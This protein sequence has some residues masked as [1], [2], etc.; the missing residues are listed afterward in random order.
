MFLVFNSCMNILKY[1]IL[2]LLFTILFC[3]CSNDASKLSEFNKCLYT[4]EY[5]SGFDIKTAERRKSVL[6]E[7]KDPWQGANKVNMQL[8]V[9]RNGESVPKDF[10]GQILIGDA[11]RIVAMSSTHIGMLDAIGATNSI[12]GVSGLKYIFS[13]DI[14]THRSKIKDIGYEGN[15]NYE[16]LLSLN[17]DIV[18]IYGV[19]GA[20]SME[21]KLQEL[22]IP[23]IYIGDYLE[24]SPLG[25]AE[26]MVAIA[27]I[28]GKRENGEKVFAEIPIKYNAL[29]KKV[30]EHA[31]NIPKV[32]L[33]IP[34]G[35]TWFMPSVNNYMARLISDAGGNYLYKKNISNSS[36]P[37]DLEE[38]Y[39]LVS[40]TD[41]WLN[42]GTLNTMNE[43][44]I[45]C[46]KF[47]D[48]SCFKS[49]KVYNNNAKSNTAGGNDYF[50]SAVVHPDLVLRDLIKIFH[51]N[52]VEEDFVY[53]K[54]LK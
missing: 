37:I 2:T 10:S 54:Q 13:P 5:A 3:G 18:L 15:I 45:A 19:N 53:Y 26:W 42:V 9:V 34:Y 31:I 8:L 48:T 47:I 23:Y 14:R 38:A 43:L 35:D 4:P 40:E 20:N 29:K 41:I 27:E 51:P 30:K 44:K 33:N 25:K 1:W 32:M 50:E 28:L 11:K 12:V 17:P 36:E 7:V 39:M 52:L 22:N 49:G 21:R 24:N 46:P 16:L 6:I